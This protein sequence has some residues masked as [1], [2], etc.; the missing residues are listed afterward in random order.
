VRGKLVMVEEGEDALV[1]RRSE[2]LRALGSGVEWGIDPLAVS[3]Q[4]P[5]RA[6]RFHNPCVPLGGAGGGGRGSQSSPSPLVVLGEAG[7]VRSF[8]LAP[9]GRTA[10]GT[11]C[12][13]EGGYSA[14]IGSWSCA[15]GLYFAWD[16]EGGRSSLLPAVLEGGAVAVVDV[17][18]ARRPSAVWEREVGG[19]R[20]VVAAGGGA[21]R[22]GAADV[23]SLFPV[24]LDG[25]SVRMGRRR[26][27]SLLAAA[28]RTARGEWGSSCCGGETGARLGSLSVLDLCPGRWMVLPARFGGSVWLRVD[29]W[30]SGVLREGL[31]RMREQ[32]SPTRSRIIRS[33]KS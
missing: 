1:T 8:P 23:S 27:R 15:P 29:E 10:C 30:R 17:D 4:V 18:S 3:V 31:E 12:Q 24:R 16:W 26:T 20:G 22:E 13:G 7:S 9:P 2:W 5:R 32:C 6:P 14:V 21:G 11:R 19:D 25:S 28:G 33:V